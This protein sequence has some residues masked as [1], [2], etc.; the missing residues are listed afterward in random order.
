MIPPPTT[1][2]DLLALLRADLAAAAYTVDGVQDLLGPVAAGALHREQ[3]LPADLA[4]RDR[5]EPLAVLVRLLALGFPVAWDDAD[6]ALPTLRADGAVRLGIARAEGADLRGTCD[7]RPYADERHVW[8]V[9]SDLSEIATG[10]PLAETHVLGIGNASTTLAEWTVRR[11]SGSALDLGVG[12]GVQSLHL[13]TH[14][15]AIVGTDTSERALAFARFT[16]ELNGVQLDLRQGSLLEPVA[17]QRFDLVVSNPPFVIT[18]RAAGVPVYEYRDAGLVGDG[19]VE[20]L[21]REVGE[22][23]R[24]G[25]VAQFLGNWE[26][27]RG[28]DWRD[29]WREWLDGTGLDAWVI[30]RDVQDPAQYAELWARDAGQRR[31]AAAY[32]VMYAAWLAD[33]ADRQ[34]EGIGF[35]VVTLQRPAGERE[36]WVDL[37][38]VG[39]PVAP[40][41]GQALD[42]GLRA[43]TALAE[44]GAAYLLDTRWR[45]AGDVTEERHS[46]PGDDDPSVILARQGGGLRRVV[47]LDTPT[48]ALLSVCD[49]ELTA[50]AALAAIAELL[51]QPEADVVASVLPTLSGLVAHGMLVAD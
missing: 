7:L 10:R 16:A 43:R 30:Q 36:P 21:V 33:F 25:G 48:A 44:G 5:P 28:H 15:D 34:V 46:R 18:P 8:W 50:R 12:S 27:R 22:H 9:A 35:G 41:V 29:R 40:A 39:G 24:P 6:R 19:V 2:P 4:T 14:C 47:R 37:D 51:E 49:G 23:L 13:A 38:E 45:V 42:A 3:R 31:G 32:E 11:R 17:G 1:D 26:I 20:T